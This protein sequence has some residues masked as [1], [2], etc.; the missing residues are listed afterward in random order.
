MEPS[1]DIF[2]LVTAFLTGSTIGSLLNVVA[3]R[4]P[5]QKSLIW[6]G[7]RCSSCMKPIAFIPW[8]IPI[9]SYLMLRGRCRMC[10]ARFSSRYFWVEL[11]T[12]SAF[13]GLMYLDGIIDS[14]HLGFVRSPGN[15]WLTPNLTGAGLVLFVK[16]A[17]LLSFLIAVSLCDFDRRIIPFSIPITG[18]LVG[19]LFAV[20]FPWPWPVEGRA[21]EGLSR[22][23]TWRFLSRTLPLPRIPQGVFPWPFWG[24]LPG[25]LS[26]GSSLTGLCNGVL[27]ALVGSFVMRSIKWVFETGLNREALGLGDAD[28]MMMAG[29]F[30]GW[31]IALISVFVGVFAEVFFVVIPMRL[32]LGSRREV[33]FAPGLAIGIMATMLMWWHWGPIF[34]PFLFDSQMMLF[35]AGFMFIGLFVSSTVLRVFRGATPKEGAG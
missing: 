1:F 29:S 9:L 2:W 23:T 25:G 35:L 27:G 19:L 6:P 31:Q 5:L 17:T 14:N 3:A 30:L 12:G 11:F 15:P 20:L 4:L 13:A 28:V 8:N 32:F 33:P 18:T 22:A 26:P 7:S 24:P 10:G 16:H 34:Q 21:V